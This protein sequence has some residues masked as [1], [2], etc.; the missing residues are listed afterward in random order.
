MLFFFQIGQDS[1][2]SLANSKPNGAVGS[3][4]GIGIY[5]DKSSQNHHWKYIMTSYSMLT[6]SHFYHLLIYFDRF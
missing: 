3:S 2:N 6:I 4:E 1:G 5:K